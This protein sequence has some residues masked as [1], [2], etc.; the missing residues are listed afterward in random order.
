M[1]KY[2]TKELSVLAEL[3]GQVR[4]L[5]FNGWPEFVKNALKEYKALPYR[6]KIKKTLI[7]VLFHG[8]GVYHESPRFKQA[9]EFL[10]EK[11]LQDMPL[12]IN[13]ENN[14]ERVVSLWRLSIER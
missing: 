1:N 7:D 10:Y 14:W 12:Y 4:S 5:E 3:I 8:F 11:G 9:Q 2:T 6:E 13:S